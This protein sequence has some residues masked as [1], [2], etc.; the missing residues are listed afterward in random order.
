M[1]GP[2][3]GPPLEGSRTRGLATPNLEPLSRGLLLR[4]E[5]LLLRQ[6]FEFRQALC[7]ACAL[8]RPPEPIDVAPEVLDFLFSRD[9]SLRRDTYEFIAF[10]DHVCN[11]YRNSY[12]FCSHDHQIL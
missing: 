1:E 8:P 12:S 9:R 10:G 11:K 4:L 2:S 6:H 3:K 7:A 5:V